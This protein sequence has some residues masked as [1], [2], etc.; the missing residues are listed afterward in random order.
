VISLDQ[1]VC[2]NKQTASRI[3]AGEAIVLTPADSRIYAFNETGSRVWELLADE[4]TVGQI[5]DRIQGEFQ[6]S[7]EQAQADVVAFLQTL[8][9]R[10]V[11]TLS[12]YV[13][14]DRR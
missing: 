14:P 4:L 10:G 7:Q 6:V 11:V 8:L 9:D 13:E 3:L 1:V 2:R 12:G 5:A